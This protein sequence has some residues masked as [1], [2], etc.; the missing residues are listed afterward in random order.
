M[1]CSVDPTVNN[2]LDTVRSRFPNVSFL[3]LGQTVLWDEPMKAVWHRLLESHYPD[4]KLIAGIHDTDYFAK[5]TGHIRTNEKF[6]ALPHDDGVTRDLWSA[7]GEMSC[8]F[9]SES[10]PSRQIYRK[11]G[12]PFDWLMKT[13]KSDRK[14]FYREF[15]AA[16][17]WL[18]VVQTESDSVIA[19]D[20]PVIDIRNALTEQID[21]AL[22]SSIKCI[23]NIEALA[24]A[25]DTAATIRGWV[26]GFLE[27]CSE[28]CRLSDLYRWLL[29]RF[30]RLLLGSTPSLLETTTS[31]R[32]FNFGPSTHDLG[33]FDIVKVFLDP[34]TRDAARAAY[35]TAVAGSG[36]YPLESFGDGA[37]PFDVVIPEVGRGTLRLMGRD[38]IIETA[39]IAT[40]VRCE[41]PVTTTLQLADAL[42]K[43]FGDDVVLV[44]KAVALADMIAA[45]FIV[46]FHES[47]SG[48]TSMT[49][50][51]NRK[52]EN[53]G[54]FLKLYPILRIKYPTWDSLDGLP[55]ST[56][57]KLPDH[58]AQA[59]GC[60]HINIQQFARRW[61][62]VVDDQRALL[63]SIATLK[64]SRSLINFLLGHRRE[65]WE[66]NLHQLDKASA[67]LQKIASRSEI[68]RNRQ[69]DL[70]QQKR[71]F[72]QERL[73]LERRMGE[74]W[75]SH[76]Q[77]VSDAIIHNQLRGVS[78]SHL[79]AEYDK[80]LAM[81]ENTFVQPLAE[82]IARID[83][84]T[85]LA[86][87]F[88]RQR[89]QLEHSAEAQS[90][91]AEVARI[92]REAEMEKL[93]IVRTAFL[94]IEGLQHT[95]DRPTSW[96]LP[97]LDP[98]NTW[99]DTIVQGTTVRW[100]TLGSESSEHIRS[101]HASS[102]LQSI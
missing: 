16:Y 30:Y 98:S 44:G 78:D 26:S 38:I 37:I 48:Y 90:Y 63:N 88:R 51:F 81:R 18:G 56:T 73:E 33:R 24:A 93:M 12:V 19:H 95:D 22:Q 97:L 35:S 28:N 8:L 100:E 87:E 85:K 76:V 99:F 3:A 5:T 102:R 75:R 94:T 36:I 60:A 64:S 50:D 14:D 57:L 34:K 9:G 53:S 31:M 86:L 68:L 72:T 52:L 79:N 67:E 39:P 69:Y 49:S 80:L 77:P 2:I 62:E 55:S 65:V 46:L 32:L 96:W 25:K 29:P 20:I 83:S 47:A 42:A 4:G 58:L 13:S 21:W 91:R 101:M 92:K 70:I 89:G 23:D 71:T 43:E 27:T 6:A 82:C 7:A 41:A 40:R 10:V 59:F 61:R 1:P 15:T 54:I 45:E 17:G 66:L 84:I 74:D 11:Y